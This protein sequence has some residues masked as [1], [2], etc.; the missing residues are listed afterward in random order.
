RAVTGVIHALLAAARGSPLQSTELSDK[1]RAIEELCLTRVQQWQSR[2]IDRRTIPHRV[3]VADAVLHE[4][5]D[6]PLGSILVAGDDTEAKLSQRGSDLANSR[7]GI[8]GGT[9][10]DD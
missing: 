1:P 8:E 4:L 3:H 2:D 6:H 10:L 7:P 5:P 9:D